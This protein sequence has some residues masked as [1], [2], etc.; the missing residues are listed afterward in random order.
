MPAA[1]G[2]QKQV[3]A[4]LSILFFYIVFDWKSS[5]I[6]KNYFSSQSVLLSTVSSNLVD[7]VD[8]KPL[9]K[10]SSTAMEKLDKG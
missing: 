3:L 10:I 6:T 7:K 4:P 5:T 9:M 1:G 8:I 2:S